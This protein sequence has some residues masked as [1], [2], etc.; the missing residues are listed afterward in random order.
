M[1]RS[2][3]LPLVIAGLLLPTEGFA[4]SR[5]IVV[6]AP[7]TESAEELRLRPMGDAPLGAR[8]GIRLDLAEK[9][10]AIDYR[11]H[12][13]R[14]VSAYYAMPV[15]DRVELQPGVFHFRQRTDP[16]GGSDGRTMIGLGAR[17]SLGR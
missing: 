9:R 14:L 4:A 2:D 15:S 10:K 3:T 16:R 12:S 7:S 13:R 6:T 17:L 1:P 11:A 5:E 8:H